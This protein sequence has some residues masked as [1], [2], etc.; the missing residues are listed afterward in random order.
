MIRQLVDTSDIVISRSCMNRQRFAEPIVLKE[1]GHRGLV[2][3]SA[4]E[5]DRLK[6]RDQ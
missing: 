5:Y 4:E 2:V 1:L 3:L 6:L